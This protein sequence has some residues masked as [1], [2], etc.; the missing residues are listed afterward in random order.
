MIKFTYTVKDPSGKTIKGIM[1]A[2]SQE[3]LIETLQN[4][5]YFILS[6]EEAQFDSSEKIDDKPA[7]QHLRKFTHDGINTSD[8]LAFAQQLA[9]MI[10]AGVNLLKSLTIIANQVESKKFSEILTKTK[11][12][13]EQ[14]ISF[15]LAISKYPKVFDTLWVSLV[16]VGEASGTMPLI[17]NKIASYIDKAESAKSKVISALIYPAILLFAAIAVV[18]AFALF[19]GPKFEDMYK[20]M[21]ADLPGLTQGMLDVFSFVRTQFL[22]LILSIV[23]FF[24]L[25]KKYASTEMGKFHIEKILFKLPIISELTLVSIVEKFTSQM[26]ILIESGVP[27]LYA[28]DII[29]RLIDNKTCQSHVMNIKKNVGQGKMLSEEMMKTDFFPPMTCQMIAVGEETGEMGKMFEHV[30]AYYQRQ[31]DVA[32]TRFT[33]AFEPIM[34]IVMACTIGFMVVAMFLPILN[35]SK[36]MSGGGV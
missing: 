4:Q 25:F 13:V 9:T 30:S 2:V 7:S 6:V 28:L 11:N 22:L 21:G 20:S 19:I 1:S 23:G 10:D 3:K 26:A 17:L 36:A 12:D 15:S 14:G 31:L 34:L 33:T 27:I 5:N 29:A 8:K 32:T 16:E 24:I 18:T 35:I